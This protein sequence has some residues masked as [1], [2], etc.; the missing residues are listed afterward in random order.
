MTKPILTVIDPTANTHPVA[1]RA[2]WLAS[3]TEQPL[4]LLICDYASYLAGGRFGDSKGLQ[5]SRRSLLDAHRKAL[6]R[7]AEQQEAETPLSV[8]VAV[9]ATWDR[10]LADGIVRRCLDAD[11][12]MVMKDTHHHGPL[13]RTLL[14][15]TDWDLIRHCPVPL[16]LVK[17]R[18][19]SAKPKIVAAIDPGHEHDK[20][21]S[22]DH[23]IVNAA[24]AI[25]N[26]V[27]G[28]LMV[29][30]CFD[31][32]PAIASGATAMAAPVAVPSAQITEALREE[33][34][35]ALDEFVAS[36]AIK[37][38]DARLIE[39]RPEDVMPAIAEEAPADLLVM[40]AVARGRFKTV[41]LG[42]TAERVLEHVPCD[43]LI[44]KPDGFESTV[45][46][47]SPETL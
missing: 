23:A 19:M 15:N 6:K 31:P 32:T 34:Q 27:G 46:R 47:E 12:A 39:G 4:E 11:A 36:S 21:A 22:T 5:K 43:V 8:N 42:H 10:P 41:F 28:E 9:E 33:H 13:K 24:A 2:W 14:S 38:L 25:A 37:G 35:A 40:G 7:L 18:P 16:W 29:V 26:Q 44:V 30:H 17:P 3:R 1:D 20:P 45:P